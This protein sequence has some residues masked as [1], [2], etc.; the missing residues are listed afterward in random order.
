MSERAAG[1]HADDFVVVVVGN[2]PGRDML[3]VAQYGH[4]VAERAHFSQAM[5]NEHRRDALAR[6]ESAMICAEPV[7]VAAGQR[8]RRLVEQQDA[9]LAEDRAGDFDLLLDG[10]VEFADFVVEMDVAMP[11]ASKCAAD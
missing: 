3:A 11:S 6:A 1:D 5:R 10:E 4:R 8:R 9:R 7:D 2:R